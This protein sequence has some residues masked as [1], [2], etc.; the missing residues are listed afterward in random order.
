MNVSKITIMFTVE[1]VVERPTP[2]LP[3]PCGSN[4]IC[5]ERN[6]AGSCSCLPEYIGNPYEGCR[7]ECVLNSDCPSNRACVRSKCVDP[8]PGTCGTNAECRVVS[9]IPTCSCFV[10]YT[11]DPYRYCSLQQ[12]IGKFY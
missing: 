12:P 3:S 10:S 1:D 6:Q 5:T 11:G 4:A 8:C 7:P 2:C 9:H